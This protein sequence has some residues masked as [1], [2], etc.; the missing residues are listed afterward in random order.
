MN[1]Y[2]C[3]KLIFDSIKSI[4]LNLEGK[5]VLTEAATGYYALMPSIAAIAGAEKVLALTRNSRYGTEKKACEETMQ[6]AE[7]CNIDQKIDVLFS[8]DDPR[9]RQADI[10]TNSGF[11]RPI[12][13]TL[14]SLLKPTVVIPLMFETWEF[15]PE[16]ID[17][18]E[19]RKRNIPVLGTNEHHPELN[20]FQ[21]VGII[22]VKLLLEIDIEI[23]NSILIIIGNGEFST[24]TNT[25][26]TKLGA[27]TYIISSDNKDRLIFPQDILRN[28]DA[29]IIAEHQNKNDLICNNSLIS[30]SALKQFAPGITVIHICGNINTNILKSEGIVIYPDRVAPVGYMSVA[31]DYV[32]P[33]P[34]IRLFTA[35]LKVGQV[36]S[37]NVTKGLR[38]EESEKAT[39]KLCDF[40]QG[41]IKN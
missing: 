3:K 36:L 14:L 2:R 16:D 21:Y 22:A 31:T 5:V 11:V 28:A 35:G 29:I 27:K 1:N 8:R 13:N 10:V 15:R 34:L 17:I 33:L 23:F 32:G 4:G 12:N 39:L 24:I 30:P 18:L 25:I 26:L 6:F 7:H 37:D 9:I 40:A 20:I 38:G 19:C 41:F